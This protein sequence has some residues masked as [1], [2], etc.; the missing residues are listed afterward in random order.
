V[1][2]TKGEI[3]K[4][5]LK[6]SIVQAELTYRRLPNVEDERDPS[7]AVTWSRHIRDVRFPYSSWSYSSRIW[8]YAS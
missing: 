3:G 7:K 4:T 1:L 5:I 8:D 2:S 6:L